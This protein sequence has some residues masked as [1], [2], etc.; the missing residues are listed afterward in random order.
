MKWEECTLVGRKQTGEDELGN[1]LFSVSD[2]K[3]CK[4]RFTPWTNEEIQLE[5]R[6]VTKNERKLL[7]RLSFPDY[8]STCSG[9]IVEGEE[10]EITKVI[11]LSPRFVLIHAKRY[12][13][14]LSER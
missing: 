12:K 5:D 9:F 11:D 6:E 4:A 2:I 3:T 1:P 8:P 14:G 13:E 7:L 10:Y